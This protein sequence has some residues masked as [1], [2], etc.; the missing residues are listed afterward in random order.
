MRI[1]NDPKVL[2]MEY[3]NGSSANNLSDILQWLPNGKMAPGALC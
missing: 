2:P 3:R 1:L